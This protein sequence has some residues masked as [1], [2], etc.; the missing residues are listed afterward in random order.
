MTHGEETGPETHQDDSAVLTFLEGLL[1]HQVAGA[2]QGATTTATQQRCQAGHP[3]MPGNQEQGTNNN[4][5]ATLP[6]SQG[7]PNH[8]PPLPHNNN[9]D[10]ERTVTVATNGRGTQHLKKA[11]LLR[12]EVWTTEHESKTRSSP[13]LPP[14]P[15]AESNGQTQKDMDDHHAT[16]GLNGS[17]KTCKGGAG[18]STLLAS[19]L[20]S[21]SSRLQN[22]ALSQQL[23]QSLKH[24]NHQQQQQ[25]QQQPQPQPQQGEGSSSSHVVNRNQQETDKEPGLCRP[26]SA[27]SQLKG[28]IKKSKAQ[29]QS[30]NNTVPYQRRRNSQERRQQQQQCQEAPPKVL[31]HQNTSS[32]SPSPN[33]SISCA[34]RLKAVANIV[35]IRSS[36]APSPRPSV[37]CSQLA[38]L[39]SSEAHLQQYSRE[40]A[41]K[42][43]LAAGR[44]ASE[45]LAAMATH[46]KT[47]DAKHQRT[48]P[49]TLSSLHVKNGSA[50]TPET[51]LTPNIQSLSGTPPNHHGRTGD[52]PRPPLP[53]RGRRPFERPFSSR[54]AQHCSSLLLQLL[55]NHNTQ[56]QL[57]SRGHMRSDL[58][59]TKYAQGSP[60]ARGDL[61]TKYAQGSPVARGDLSTKYAQGSPVARGDL[62][63]K[64]AQGSPVARADLSTRYAHQGSPA[65]RSDGGGHSS[66][67]SSFPKDSSDA[68]SS[69][70]SSCTPIDLSLKGRRVSVPPQ[71][72]PPP[73][74]PPVPSSSSSSSSTSSS[75]ALDRITEC[76]KWKTD[77]ASLLHST[78]CNN[79][80]EREFDSSSSN[81]EMKP[82]HK[83]TLLQLLLDHK[84]NGN[85]NNKNKSLSNPD[86]HPGVIP[87]VRGAPA[88]RHTVVNRCEEMTRTRSPQCGRVSKSPLILPPLSYGKDTRS[89]ASSPYSLVYDSSSHSQSIPLDL[90][91]S[92]KSFP[93]ESSVSEAGF[94]ASM[95]LQNLAQSGKQSVSPSPPPLKTSST[96][97][98]ASTV[99][100]PPQEKRL[101]HSL[102]LLERLNAPPVQQSPSPRS[103]GSYATTASQQ[104]PESLQSSSEIENLLER[105]TVLQLLLGNP[106]S[107]DKVGCNKR[108]RELGRGNCQDNKPFS[109][110]CESLGV[111]SQSPVTMMDI[112]VAVKT[113]PE[114]P[115]EHHE[116]SGP[117][118]QTRKTSQNILS[119][120]SSTS[121]LLSVP[122]V[123]VIKQEPSSSPE[124][125]PIP[126][127][128]L[129]SHLLKQPRAVLF[130]TSPGNCN[131][132]KMVSVKEEVEQQ[133]EQQH[134][135]PTIP[136]KRKYSP[137]PKA[138]HPTGSET[139]VT[140][141]SHNI[142]RATNSNSNNNN[143][144]SSGFGSS[145]STCSNSVLPGN[146]EVK[147]SQSPPIADSPPM[148][149]SA[150]AVSDSPPGGDSA[151]GFNVLKQLLLSNNSLRE[152]SPQ[153]TLPPTGSPKH[154]Y[155]TLSSGG[156]AP[157]HQSV[158]HHNNTDNK[159]TSVMQ[160]HVPAPADPRSQ[161]AGLTMTHHHHHHH[162]HR[163]TA[164][165]SPAWNA[166][167]TQGSP[168]PKVA[169]TTTSGDEKE[170]EEEDSQPDSPRLMRSNPILYYM[171]QKN[172]AEKLR[173]SGERERGRTACPVLQVKIKEEP[174]SSIDRQDFMQT[175][176]LRQ[177]EGD[178]NERS[179]SEAQR[180]NGSLKK[181]Q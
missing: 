174:S 95:L 61:S 123:T 161:N 96:T 31:Q 143:S 65:A 55:N 83:V 112:P 23:V 125:V 2:Q 58:S 115:S 21:F 24:H 81:H 87:K 162:H 56:H 149:C 25:P 124:T 11:R 43:Q 54:P 53:F 151:G 102:T 67:D 33:G 114:S 46:N 4:N 133:P 74:P 64:Y 42:A 117:E 14:L 37:A 20:Q 77:P 30:S 82:H 111:S 5:K 50:G 62:S 93:S 167:G 179:H 6:G 69:C 128:G 157:H 135:G 177:T 60:V 127:D 57:N 140:P 141:D 122:H 172:N 126:R 84:N 49:D 110:Q 68:E 8:T 51:T 35:N 45:R 176:N 79:N 109:S 98:A 130:S 12:S 73:P 104:R 97:V 120:S 63:T 47:P 80:R 148:R 181:T 39:L 137:E 88:A 132:Q 59:T 108:K 17:S 150:A 41:L 105:R 163:H 121:G 170:E 91:K 9:A 107:K 118:R 85:V 99:Q 154:S 89:N 72:P 131:S 86:L 48:T 75:P 18:E 147:G 52:S 16:S 136:K 90:C 156:R 106:S 160:V 169:P 113:E 139:C 142:Q 94:S 22:V 1:M 78:I 173:E 15:P 180:L 165:G 92:N 44:S 168:K 13:P 138:G 40:Q 119:D 28:L 159:T 152:F 27:S 3:G 129:L 7:Q 76:L 175:L 29:N 158:D 171:L 36:P 100:R 144:S 164:P 38:L 19:L 166:Q 34:N 71:P 153:S 146:V 101:N 155:N 70:S 32:S 116:T 66:P 134:Q 26:E 178:Q 103:D 10:L 145:S